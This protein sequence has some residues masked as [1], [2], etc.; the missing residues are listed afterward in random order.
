[1]KNPSCFFTLV[2][3]LFIVFEQSYAS[4]SIVEFA[5]KFNS[6]A[7]TARVRDP[8][9]STNLAPATRARPKLAKL[10][11]NRAPDPCSAKVNCP[12]TCGHDTAVF[13]CSCRE[14]NN[15]CGCAC[16]QDGCMAGCEYVRCDG[17][18][19]ELSYICRSLGQ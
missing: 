6:A 3:L 4:S 10:P 5:P 12:Q 11:A 17:T 19:F 14:S 2:T 18:T 13:S 7:G 1:M 8:K 15:I 9:N 16:F